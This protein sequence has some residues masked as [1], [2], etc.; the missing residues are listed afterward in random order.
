[1]KRML[2]NAAQPEELRV[3]LVDGQELYDLDVEVP[4][5]EQKKGNIYKGRISRIE[6]SLEACFVEYGAERHGFLPLR[7]IAPSYRKKDSEPGEHQSIRGALHEGQE[8]IVQVEKEERGTKGAALTTFVSLAGRY[9]VL[10]P[11][12]PRG[13]GISKRLEGEDRTEIRDILS[14]LPIPEGMSVIIR[15]AGVGHSLE[16]INW[17]LD[18]MR[19]LWESI[20]QAAESRP[21]PF[22]IYQESNVIIRALRDHFTSDI[23]EVLV[24][25]ENIYNDARGFVEM[26]MPEHLNRLKHYQ[27]KVPLFTRFQI[28]SQIDAAYQR[29]VRLPSGGTLV[30]DT[31]EALISIDVN[32]ARATQGSDINETA[33]NTNLE[34]ASEISRQLKLRD[35]GGLVVIDFID[36]N[37]NRHQ[38]EVENRLREALDSDRARVQMGRISRFGLLELSRQRLRPSLNEAVLERCP[39]CEGEGNI[40]SVE[41][42][43][44][45]V[46]RL[47]HE[48]AIKEKTGRVMVEVPVPVATYLMNEKRQNLFNIESQCRVSVV[49]VPNP[50]MDTPAFR[51]ER[52]RGDQLGEHTTASH[53]VVTTPAV[54]IPSTAAARSSA[55]AVTA[56]RPAAPMP[57]GTPKKP[58]KNQRGWFTRLL[59]ALNGN[60]GEA[61]EK[62]GKTKAKTTRKTGT[63]SSGQS[64]SRSRSGT[65]R[66][67]RGSSNR[68]GK[69]SGSRSRRGSG[70]NARGGNRNRRGSGSGSQARGRPAQPE[71]KTGKANEDGS[72]KATPSPSSSSS[73]NNGGD[74]GSQD[75][76][77]TG[78]NRSRTRRGRRGGRRRRSGGQGGNGNNGN[79]NDNAGNNGSEQASSKPSGETKAPPARENP[80]SSN[81]PRRE[82]SGE[83]KPVK[84]AAA[85]PPTSET[86]RLAALYSRE[87]QDNANSSN[88]GG[89]QDSE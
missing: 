7:E 32:S 66:N 87:Q 55:P 51:I 81:E 79:R 61:A 78:V 84:P 4:S 75:K 45:S 8:V 17:D 58:E 38:R 28:E 18:Y 25:E 56:L 43:S 59:G 15:T 52:V 24:D 67:G 88:N 68:G 10:K 12:D 13:G 89:S 50:H 22:L 73:A 9:L 47:I 54:D 3:A 23:G 77:G 48:E 5:A 62:D 85:T 44:I 36:M 20:V 83:T 69:S 11:N 33:F 76:A 34:A 35:L 53:Q 41:S 27:D 46:L 60:G 82:T 1:M 30:F 2:I 65:E 70:G 72:Q 14:Q 26:V 31:T 40:R 6:P 74:T 42:L 37:S 39:R 16:Q 63:G 21:A 57:A 19:R 86:P 80:P 71:P 49:V 29:R 64:R